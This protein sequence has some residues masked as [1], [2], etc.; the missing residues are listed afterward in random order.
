MKKGILL[1]TLC[2]LVLAS[3]SKKEDLFDRTRIDEEAKE[4]FPVDNIDPDHDW[5]M[6]GVGKVTVSIN[7]GTGET[8]TVRLYAEDPFNEGNSGKILKKVTMEDGKSVVITTDMPD[9][10]DY[11]YVVI[12]DNKFNKSLKSVPMTDNVG[13]V[14]FGTKSD[15]RSVVSRAV[16]G[17]TY[18]AALKPETIKKMFEVP[19]AQELEQM[20]S[21][22]EYEYGKSVINYKV[23]NENITTVHLGGKNG[24][25]LYVTADVKLK[26]L[27]LGTNTTIHVLEG[28]CLEMTDGINWQ[29]N[30]KI[31]VQEKGKL[32]LKKNNG[33]SAACIYNR[34]KIEA[35]EGNCELKF[36]QD[37]Y[38]YNGGEFENDKDF[39]HI[40]VNNGC[41]FV[42]AS[43]LDMKYLDLKGGGTFINESGGEVDVHQETSV[44]GNWVNGGKY[45]TKNF[46]YTGDQYTV[47]NDCRLEV[48]TAFTM[49]T[50][51]GVYFEMNGGS[52]L[53]VDDGQMNLSQATIK[54]GEGAVIKTKNIHY[55]DGNRIIGQGNS[56]ALV[57]VESNTV[58]NSD[59]NSPITYSG[60]LY[61]TAKNVNEKG[62]KYE[63]KAVRKPQK[64]VKLS[65][66]DDDRCDT[67]FD[68][69]GEER[70]DKYA[71]YT[72]VYEDMTR[73][74]GD[75]DFNDIVLHVTVPDEKG[76]V[77][78]TL[79]A[80]GATKKLWVGFDG[81]Q[82]NNDLF[83][84]V[85]KAMGCEEGEMINT[86]A[87]PVGKQP[88]CTI[89]I[90]VGNT[91]E[92]HGKL[93]IYDDK[94]Y[95]I[96]VASIYTPKS[97]Y[98]PYG[99]VI[100][101]EWTSSMYPSERQSIDKKYTY[102]A[103]WAEHSNTYTKWY[104][105]HGN[106][107]AWKDNNGEYPYSDK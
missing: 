66:D 38:I 49:K 90:G 25:T 82:G 16:A 93:Y 39:D 102:F 65:D 87:G 24:I 18:P 83:G 63:G 77:T 91:L 104:E 56:F 99:L 43:E 8:Y 59:A 89:H 98:P 50:A 21:F 57:Y 86:G 36:S 37:A 44:N 54:M 4:N 1:F 41:V 14:Y 55:A 106:V 32:I 10:I 45:E 11:L 100:P 103:K 71:V 70:P 84:E 76:D 33:F 5:K 42:N 15:G 69:K 19:S 2:F 107:Q 105:Q 20:P 61:V 12:E 23:D 97:G 94:G 30:A 46:K 75:F 81:T 74:V 60:N 101:Y 31:I 67:P 88:E 3:C 79:F 80:A 58:G 95:R 85:H 6:A 28:G 64:D 35:K 9:G 72:Y 22:S 47:R 73:E 48:G 26:S 68:I 7:E 52:T 62:T 78:V 40:E 53:E 92:S 34:G 96:D 27:T 13:E 17:I 29:Q 51:T